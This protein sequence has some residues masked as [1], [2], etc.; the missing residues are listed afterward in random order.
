MKRANRVDESNINGLYQKILFM[1]NW[2]ILGLK[3]EHPHKSGLASR[4]ALNFAE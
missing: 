3:V 2:G 1:T 4:F